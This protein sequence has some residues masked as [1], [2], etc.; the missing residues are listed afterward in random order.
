VFGAVKVISFNTGEGRFNYRSVAVILHAGHLLIHRAEKDDFWALPGGRVEFQEYS[1]ATVVREIKEEL[2]LESIVQRQ[3][4]HVENF[5]EYQSERY[6]E[7]AN[8]Y[9]LAL[10]QSPSIN[11]GADFKGIEQSVDLIFRWVPVAEIPDYNLKPDF[12]SQALSVNGP[13]ELP[14]AIEHI[15]IDDCNLPEPGGQE[16]LNG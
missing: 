8:Y 13:D 5:F 15:Q 16:C 11:S 2:G 9:L 12:L 1:D 6:H 3:L 10:V 7:L 14:D 4:W